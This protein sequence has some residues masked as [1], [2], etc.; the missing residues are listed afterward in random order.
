MEFSKLSV[1]T[2]VKLSKATLF[3][4]KDNNN[5]ITK[6]NLKPA[7]VVLPTPNNNNILV[8]NGLPINRSPSPYTIEPFNN[9][10]TEQQQKL[11][12]SSYAE[13]TKNNQ[14]TTNLYSNSVNNIMSNSCFSIKS[15]KVGQLDSRRRHGLYSSS[16][17]GLAY[18]VFDEEEHRPLYIYLKNSFRAA[19]F[20]YW[21]S[22][23]VTILT[24]ISIQ[25]DWH[26]SALF[27][28]TRQKF[29]NEKQKA[30]Y[31]YKNIQPKCWKTYLDPA[32][33]ILKTQ[34]KSN[35][36][37]YTMRLLAVNLINDFNTTDY[38]SSF[39][40]RSPD[41]PFIVIQ[42]HV[43]NW[44]V[45]YYYVEKPG[46]NRLFSSVSDTEINV[47]IHAIVTVLV[48]SQLA[49]FIYL[50]TKLQP[51]LKNWM[52]NGRGLILSK[53]LDEPVLIKKRLAPFFTFSI[54]QIIYLLTT[55]AYR[56]HTFELF[57]EKSIPITFTFLRLPTS[58]LLYKV[59]SISMRSQPVMLK[60][61]RKHS[62]D[63]WS[64]KLEWTYKNVL[65]NYPGEFAKFLLCYALFLPAILVYIEEKDRGL[66]QSFEDVLWNT[67]VTFTNLG[68]TSTEVVSLKLTKVYMGLV[69]LT[70]SMAI[71]ILASVL[72]VKLSRSSIVENRIMIE[73]EKA[74]RLG[75]MEKIAATL[76][77]RTWRRY[78]Q[79]G[80]K[81]MPDDPELTA[82]KCKFKHSKLMQ[83]E[84]SEK[85]VGRVIVEPDKMLTEQEFEKQLTKLEAKV[86]D[87]D[88]PPC[89]GVLRRRETTGISISI[90]E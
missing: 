67:L 25:L 8:P 70:G 87:F 23:S 11:V 65:L 78:K 39:D 5:K 52:Q 18:R 64:L 43:N 57:D 31:M 54:D 3:K 16:A 63:P 71:A 24:I 36:A 1:S 32:T 10:Q 7:A 46:L 58:V 35:Q 59:M 28:K 89:E 17:S 79:L 2:T 20:N 90:T 22:V 75:Q 74:R 4:E 26:D 41:W 84:I 15:D 13:N 9:N 38:L 29:E 12:F 69:S 47:A 27:G 30:D 51:L 86:N 21:A 62:A 14:T 34:N 6:K 81:I 49:C 40:E 45:K 37:F 73:I 50:F 61:I 19:K 53:L 76:I 68:L 80:D 55:I 56:P 48:V 88:K 66:C 82:A 83:L 77:Q 42:E 72:F 60:S 85:N 44:H 33:H